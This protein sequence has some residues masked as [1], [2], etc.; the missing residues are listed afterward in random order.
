MH[1]LNRRVQVNL[2]L[3][4][5]VSIVT[6]NQPVT[7]SP[8][9]SLMT[10]PSTARHL[11]MTRLP[12]SQIWHQGMNHTQPAPAMKGINQGVTSLSHSE[13]PMALPSTERNEN[14]TRLPQGQIW[15]PGMNHTQTLTNNSEFC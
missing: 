11:D 5:V 7:Q 4:T 8:V 6:G 2:H 15:H 14:G 10:Q 1:N 9:Y 13:P 12:Q 3:N